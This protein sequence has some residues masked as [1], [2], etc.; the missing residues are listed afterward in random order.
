MTQ[1][2]EQ[3]TKQYTASKIFIFRNVA[4]KMVA[5]QKEN[6]K[7][8]KIRFKFNQLILL[9]YVHLFVREI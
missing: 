9:K 5:S 7:S 1:N 4:N 3:Y 2:V 8:K 6:D